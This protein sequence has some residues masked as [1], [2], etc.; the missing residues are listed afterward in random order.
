MNSTDWILLVMTIIQTVEMYL[1]VHA[2]R[3]TNSIISEPGPLIRAAIRDLVDDLAHDK[4]VQKEFGALMATAG[5]C[6]IAGAKDV[7]AQAGMVPPKIRKP[8]DLLQALFQLPKVQAA[9]EK[10]MT[11]MVSG[12]VEEKAAETVGG[13]G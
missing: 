11:D 10:K 8:T 13:W 4:E 3:Q 9:L 6:I 12:V 1:I 7:Y 5:Q 2:Q